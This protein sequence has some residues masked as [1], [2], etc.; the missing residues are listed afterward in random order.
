MHPGGMQ[1]LFGIKADLATY[2]KVVGGGLPVGILAGKA[3]FMDA[4]D[5]G[6]WRYGDASYPETGMTFFA[7][8]FV[9]H[10]LVMAAVWAVLNY[11]KEQGPAL[12]ER[13]SARTAALVRRIDDFARRRGVDLKI[14]TFGSLFFFNIAGASP[15]ASLFY[16]HML[17]RGVY[18]QEH[19]PCFLT[20]AHSDADIAAIAEA[21]EDSIAA[22]QAADLMPAASGFGAKPETD[23][24]LTEAQTEIWLAAQLS[25]EASCAFNES[26]TLRLRGALNKDALT[27]ALNGVLARHDALRGAFQANGERMRILPALALEPGERDF[28]QTPQA[29]EAWRELLANEAKTPFDLVNGPLIRA[30][31]VRFAADDHA[32][33]LTAHH[34]VCDGWSF[35]VIIERIDQAL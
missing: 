10:P 9:R 3:V 22:M 33:V 7:G 24:P 34:I 20:T 16:P 13:V 19:Y 18:L 23:F 8:T 27:K 2:G 32:L 26:I 30:Q 14:E 35:N 25:E 17:D 1:A 4:L 5:G 15:Y 12:Q 29:A 6:T 11:L 21:F 31:L 28:V